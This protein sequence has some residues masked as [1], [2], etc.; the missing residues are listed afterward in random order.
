M[1]K[2]V[3][4]GSAACR[5][6]GR[7]SRR[8]PTEACQTVVDRPDETNRGPE[9]WTDGV[10]VRANAL[11]RTAGRSGYCPRRG[12]ATTAAG[13]VAGAGAAAGVRAGG[14]S[15]GIVAALSTGAAAAVAP[16]GTPGGV[17]NVSA[18]AGGGTSGG[19]RA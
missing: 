6:P 3:A 15:G 19:G 14:A 16:A 5:S 4:G 17:G 11:F 7:A 10:P 13:A 2:P 9:L 8:R 1:S 12:G 18:F